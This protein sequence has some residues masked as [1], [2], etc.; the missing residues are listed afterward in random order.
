MNVNIYYLKFYKDVKNILAKLCKTEVEKCMGV[1]LKGIS[2]G[3]PV[4]DG[5]V[6]N[7]KQESEK[8]TT[9]GFLF[10]YKYTNTYKYKYRSKYTKE[11]VM[12]SNKH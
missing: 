3:L 9:V 1:Q 4:G 7:T 2:G 12:A 10:K 6:I 8:T 5:R 11:L